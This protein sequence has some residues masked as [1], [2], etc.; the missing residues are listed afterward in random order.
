MDREEIAKYVRDLAA[1]HQISYVKT[2]TDHLAEN[3]TRLCGDDVGEPDEIQLLLVALRRA[4]HLDGREF[5]GL[6]ADYLRA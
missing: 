4:G 2:A 6:Q 1:L 3:I 5:I